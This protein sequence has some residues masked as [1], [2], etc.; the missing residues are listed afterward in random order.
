M[1]RLVLLLMAVCA[2]TAL[3]QTPPAQDAI[4]TLTLDDAIRLALQRNKNLKVTSFMPGIARANLLVARGAF[5][6]SLVLNRQYSSSQF[7]NSI[8]PIPINDLT[9]TDIYSVGVQGSLPVGTQYNVYGSTVE[10]R[11]VYNGITK[12]YQTFGGFT[13]TQPLLKGFGFAANLE[14]VRIQKANRS[15]SDLT[16]Q[17]SAINTVTNVIVAYSNLQ[18]AHDELESA[19]AESALANGQV[20]DNEKKF[21]AGS[22]AQSDVI[23]ER[24]YAAQFVEQILIAE[25][26]VRDAQNALRELIGEDTFFEDEPLFVLAPMQLPEINVDRRADLQRA[27]MTRPDYLIER[28]VIVQDHAIE[29]AARNSLLPQVDFQGGYGYNGSATNFSPSRQMVEDH[30]NPS[31]SAGLTVTIPFTF[32]VGRGTLRAAKLTRE[33]ADENLRSMAADIAVAVA[34]ADGQIETT[35]KRVVADQTAVDLAKQALEA[36][37][38]KNKAGTGS[39]YAVI[40]QQQILAQAENGVSVALANERQAVAVYDQTLGTTLERYHITLT[41]EWAIGARVPS[42]SATH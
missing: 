2:C 1:R 20:R 35:R 9:K 11:D 37:E 21:S 27:L 10:T 29:A 30:Q 31:V 5:D 18:L 32:A 39:T 26:S 40:Q 34:T 23:E 6:P 19:E 14:Q 42:E 28:F 13:V 16:Y 15:I 36:E 38:K 24:A 12:N 4:P 25:R 41:D 22:A 8:G 33:Q 3:A 17:Q 7:N